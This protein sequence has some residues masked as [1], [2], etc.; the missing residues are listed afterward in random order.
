MEKKLTVQDARESLSS[1]IAWKGWELRE[2]YGRIGWIELLRILEDRA[3][4][5]YPCEIVFS[6]EELEPGEFAF[7]APRGER[8]EDGFFMYVHP[9][10]KDKLEMVP[11]L[12]LYQ[13]VAVNYGDFASAEDA[14][15]FGAESLGISRDEF[16]LKLSELAAQIED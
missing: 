8:P 4:C 9:Y 5:R 1:H 15:T 14:E 13:L 3:E 10:F 11:L 12:V 16:Y 6:S 2:K 7:P